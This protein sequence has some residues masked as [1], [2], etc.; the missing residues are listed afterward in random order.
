MNAA[1]APEDKVSL[2]PYPQL[3][4]WLARVEALPGFI[5]MIKSPVGLAA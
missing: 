5:P 2:E 4:A 3:R 1:R